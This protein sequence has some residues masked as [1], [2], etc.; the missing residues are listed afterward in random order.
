M[1]C[2]IYRSSKRE[3]TYLYLDQ[4]HDFSGIP[5]A[6]M[7]GF[8][9]PEVAMILSLDGSKK[10]ANADADKVALAIKEQGYYL[11]LP[12][13]PEN[14]LSAHDNTENGK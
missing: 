6:L 14:L 8:G 12:P 3:L 7:Q 2:T 1:F 9:K 11:Q 4:K 13:L 10:L 5:A